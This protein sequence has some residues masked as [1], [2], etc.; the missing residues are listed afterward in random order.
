MHFN[1][2]VEIVQLKSL[3]LGQNNPFIEKKKKNN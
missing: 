1:P 2:S 3:V